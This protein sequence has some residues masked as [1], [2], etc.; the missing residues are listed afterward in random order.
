M[1]GMQ[2]TNVFLHVMATKE[3]KITAQEAVLHDLFL[4]LNFK[5][6]NNAHFKLS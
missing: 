1:Q 4:K 6:Q 2:L 5:F 3:M